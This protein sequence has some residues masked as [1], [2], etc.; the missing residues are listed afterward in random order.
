[1]RRRP[2][3]STLFPYTTLFRSGVAPEEVLIAF[4][5]LL[6][7]ALVF[8]TIG[9]C[10]SAW[11]RSTIGAAAL[12][13]GTMLLPVVA[14]PIIFGTVFSFV[15]AILSSGS[16]STNVGLQ[17]VLYYI[18][19]FLICLNPFIAGGLTEAIIANNNSLWF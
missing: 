6:A 3:R 1:M 13:Y 10:F 18:G 12:A 9:L 7:S 17:I 5:M 14:L 11:V 8:G 16:S 2:P 15:A 4:V 19:G